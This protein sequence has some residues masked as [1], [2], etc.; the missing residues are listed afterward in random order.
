MY[1]IP[2][3][4]VISGP[5]ASG[6][7]QIAMELAAQFNGSIVN[8]D[9]MQIYRESV[10]LNA[11]PSL[12][13]IQ[14]IPHYLYGEI[15]LKQ[16]CSVGLWLDWFRELLKQP[17]IASQPLFVVGG[18]GLYIQALTQGLAVIPAV[19]AVIKEEIEKSW[20]QLG[21]E[22]FYQQFQQIDPLM[23]QRLHPNDRQRLIRAW[24]VKQATGKSLF[25]WWQT[26]NPVLPIK[27]LLT[28][29]VPERPF[30]YAACDQR[31]LRMIKKGGVEE[32]AAIYQM[33]LPRHLPGMGILGLKQLFA[34]FEGVITREQAIMLGQQATRQYAKR[35]TTWFR[36]Q[37]PT[38]IPIPIDS[39]EQAAIKKVTTTLAGQIKNFLSNLK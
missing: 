38:A 21:P 17:L 39:H 35:Q 34:H 18:T 30:L 36:N 10:V 16:P 11:R 31:F 22:S 6:K 5:T 29:L 1:H 37:M 12:L 7:S 2:P 25:E 20:Q 24:S 9:S 13:D 14:Q 26:G 8:A 15:S 4:I 32:A 3:V 23:A 33:N 28:T 27:Y 19:P